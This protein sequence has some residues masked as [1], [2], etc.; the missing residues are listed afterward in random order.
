MPALARRSGYHAIAMQGMRPAFWNLANIYPRIGFEAY[1][2]LSNGFKLDEE[3]GLGLSDESFLRQSAEFLARMP[4]PYYAFL[5]TLSSH[6]PFNQK[7]LPRSL[8]LGSLEGKELGD[9]LDAQH[10]TDAAIGHFV[11]TLAR[12]G[13]LDKSVLVIYGDHFGINRE[14]TA[15]AD[16]SQLLHVDTLN[17]AAVDS[18]T[19][20]VPLLVRMP[21][22]AKKD[23]QRVG[24]EVD[25]APT[26]AGILGFST[27][28][29]YFM[30]RNLLTDSS[31]VVSLRDGS[32]LNN[33]YFWLG[34]A[35]SHSGQCY[36]FASKTVTQQSKCFAIVA[37]AARER[38][39]SQLIVEQN[40]VSKLGKPLTAR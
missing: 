31:G 20:Q 15:V 26:L 34:N 14:N 9:Y 24:G 35:K 38:Q 19:W 22:G 6:S 4:E 30:G 12:D 37:Q 2:N 23:V 10:Y 27:D 5:I 11:E 8:Q 32:V 3:I 16:L 1:Y 36:D 33:D 28:D 18:L 21:G 13:V 25:I 17:D 29:F 7:G 39:V 40:L